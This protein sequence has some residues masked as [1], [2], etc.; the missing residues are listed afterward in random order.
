[1]A[2]QPGLKLIERVEEA[3]HGS[4]IGLLRCG[5]SRAIDSVVHVL[6]DEAIEVVDLFPDAV[7][8]QV[9]FALG[10]AIELAVEHAHEIVVG[11]GDDA[12]CCR[13]PQ[14]RNSESPPIVRI[15]GLVG[16]AEELKS[17]DGIE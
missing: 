10:E 9:N 14:H 2:C 17:V 5:E 8:I 7:L 4:F 3:Q 15:G 6:V 12:M 11:I 16:L 1:M 13:V